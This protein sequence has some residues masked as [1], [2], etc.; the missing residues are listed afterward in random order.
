MTAW[1][2]LS[3]PPASIAAA[4][5]A[6]GCRSSPAIEKPATAPMSIMPSTPRFRTPARSAKI[7]PI[8]ANSRIVPLATPAARIDD[9]VHQAAASRRVE[10]DA[11]ADSTSLHDER[12]TG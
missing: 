6:T 1:S 11:V 12:R 5:P 2:R 8:A 7:S 10:A 3:R 4:S 9:R